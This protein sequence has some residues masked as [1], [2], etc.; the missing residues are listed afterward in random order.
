MPFES[1]LFDYN[2]PKESINQKP[3]KNPNNSKLLI[4]ETNEVIKFKEFNKLIKSPSLFIL[5]KSTVRNV[6]IETRKKTEGAIEIFILEILGDNIAKC[7]L[8][9]SNSKKLNKKYDLENF[10]FKIIKIVNDSFHIH[11]NKSIN[12]II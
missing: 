1:K 3:Y 8:R 11:T 9:S 4:A 5:N 10:S 6:R 2:L 12:E 7:L